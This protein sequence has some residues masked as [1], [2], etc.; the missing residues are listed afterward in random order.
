MRRP[1][2]SV[3]KLAGLMM[4]QD[5]DQRGDVDLLSQF[6]VA[7][8]PW[9]KLGLAAKRAIPARHTLATF[10][11][12]PPHSRWLWLAYPDWL[13]SR[14]KAL[15]LNLATPDLREEVVRAREI[16][17]WLREPL[18]TSC[19]TLG[20]VL[21]CLDSASEDAVEVKAELTISAVI[22]LE[23]GRDWP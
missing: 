10:A 12:R 4:L 9:A 2:A 22:W 15:G 5:D 1:P 21:W 8:S 16:K 7:R 23:L 11:D 3:M 19:V 13:V 14:G 6:G 17:Q 18:Q 20:M